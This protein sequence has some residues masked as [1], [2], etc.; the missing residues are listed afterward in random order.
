M[1]RLA[2]LLV[3]GLLLGM[4]AKAGPLQVFIERNVEADGS[5]ELRFIH[6]LTGE[7]TAVKVNGERYTPVGPAIMYLDTALNRVRLATADGRVRNHPF[8]QPRSDTRRLDWLVAESQIAWTLTALLPDG[9]LQTTTTVANLDGSNP[10]EVLVDGPRPGIRALPVAFTPD[11][12]GLYMD[13]QPDGIADFTPFQ[14]YAGLFRVDFDEGAAVMLPGE[15]GCFCAAGLGADTLLRL[16][17]APDLSGFDVIV[18][19]L[20]AA[21]TDRI[22]ALRLTNYTQAGNF[23]IA[24]DGSLAVYALAQIRDFGGPAQA[25]QTVFVLV[26][27]VDKTQS[28]LTDPITT[29]VQPVEW[30]EDNTAIIFTSADPNL[31]GTWKITL[32]D[33]RL[34]RVASATYIGTLSS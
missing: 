24:P 15:P 30:T 23:I 4:Q 1:R 22:P 19:N 3:A 11:R 18:T 26:N 10:R 5:D 7:E 9:Q 12:A 2:L 17:L 8:I 6:L 31:D 14:Q 25:V 34:S 21:T 20:G 27:L 32:K 33:G 28:T 29:F 16:D 13:Y